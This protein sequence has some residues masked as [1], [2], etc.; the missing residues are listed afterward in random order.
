M[1]VLVI[2]N[3]E[4]DD[5]ASFG[6]TFTNLFGGVE[7]LE[8]ANI[9]CREGVP[10]TATCDRFLKISERTILRGKSAVTVQ[11]AHDDDDCKQGSQKQSFFR[12]HRWTVFFWAREAI[13]ATGKWKCKALYDFVEDFEPDLILLMIYPYSYINKLA[14]HLADKYGIPMVTHVSDDDYSLHQRSWSPLY[15]ANRLFQRRWIRRAVEKSKALYC[16]TDMQREEYSK[17]FS[18]PCRLLVKGVKPGEK[19]DGKDVGSPVKLL[20]AGNLGDGR[21]KSVLALGKA[22]ERVNDGEDKMVLDVFTPT[23]LPKRAHRAFERLRAITVS[24]KIPYDEVVRCQREADVL[25]HAESFSKKYALRVRHSLSTKIVDSL[26]MNRCL[27][28]IG[29]RGVASIE[30]LIANDCAVVVTDKKE[31][32]STLRNTILRAGAIEDYAQKGYECGVRLH[33]LNKIRAEFVRD[34]RDIVNESSAD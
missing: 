17:Y 30:Y 16:M 29:P 22:I 7:E 31:I 1:K 11:S 33:D 9:Y 13:W 4:W 34:L 15:W 24:G 26:A 2:S 8:L 28:A 21:W 5:S 19:P 12:R 25:V 3:S 27:L 10:A 6:N 32:D 23:A 14:V 20:Y 18:V